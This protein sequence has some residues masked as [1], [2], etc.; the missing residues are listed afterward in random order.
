MGVPAFPNIIG[1]RGAPA[2]A[3]ENT[4]AAFN[5]ALEQGAASI[6]CDV[7]LTADDAI[8]I[9]HDAGVEAVTD[10]HGAVAAL[11]LAQIRALTVHRRG[12]PAPATTGATDTA[13]SERIPT[14]GE[15]LAAF[16]QRD[17]T[18]N[19]EIKPTGSPKLA[20]AAA[21]L[22][23]DRGLAA[24]VVFSSFDRA[25]LA[26][27]QRHHAGLRRALLFPPTMLARIMAGLIGTAGWIQ[28]ARTL[29][30]EAVHPY[31]QIA[32]ART[33]Q[34]AHAQGLR[35]NVW[36]VDDPAVAAKL[37]ALGVDG[38]IT[39]DPMRLCQLRPSAAQ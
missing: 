24:T 27:L 30:C 16:G 15:F 20:A 34:R 3:P 37:A 10:G 39:N 13:S 2:Y 26:Y 14:F 35:I 17:I 5:L 6:E 12:T 7:R 19:V 4:I 21:R 32:T 31:W 9:F 22:V 36:T 18:L 28:Q 1:H 33:V 23:E 25:V 8:V 38:I 29:G 11:T